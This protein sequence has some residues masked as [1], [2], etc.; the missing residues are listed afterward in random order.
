MTDAGGAW[1]LID[2]IMAVGLGLSVIVGLWRGLVTELLSLAGWAVSYFMAQWFGPTAGEMLPVGEPGSR[3]NL[4]AGMVVVFVLAWL[5]WALLSWAVV[6][7][8][9]ASVLSGPDRLMGAVFGLLRGVLVIL[10]VVTL[11]SLTPVAKWAPWKQSRGVALTHVLIDGMRPMLPAKV[12]EYLPPPR[13]ATEVP[14]DEPMDEPAD[15]PAGRAGG[16]R[17]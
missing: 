14:A 7:V 12:I 5:C 6:Q 2:V 9:R 13:D 4:V 1:S 11:L 16:G 3:L 10:A 15:E 8:V 17:V